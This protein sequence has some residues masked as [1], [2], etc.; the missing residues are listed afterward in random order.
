MINTTRLG[1]LGKLSMVLCVSLVLSSCGFH[2]Q[3]QSLRTF[4][5]QLNLYV[6]DAQLASAVTGN[7]AQNKV[8]VTLLDS[9]VGADSTAPTLLL[10]R[11]L[12]HSAELTLDSNGEPLVWRYTLSSQ[13]LYSAAGDTNHTQENSQAN[14]NVL[15]SVPISVTTDVDLS[16]ANATVNARIKADSWAL[17][18][19]QLGNSITRKLSFQ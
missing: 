6:D 13:Y 8:V 11:T 3:G 4:P 14:L 1:V 2:L 19:K 10:T 12:Q 17:L 15:G 16:G 5:P 7:L 18:Y 9:V